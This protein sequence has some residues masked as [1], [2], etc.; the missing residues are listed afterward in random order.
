MWTDTIAALAARHR[1]YA[2][3]IIGD[4][5]F[6][7]NRRAISKPSDYV[8]WLDEVLT[9][10]VPNG[11]VSLLGIS[12]GGSIA[13]QYALRHPGRLRAVVLLAPGATVLPMSARFFLRIMFLS[14]PLPGREGSLRRVCRWLFED[15]AHGDDA[16]RARLDRA[17]EELER[18]IRVF[19]L[20]R[21][22][23]PAVLTDEEWRS[24]RVPC[25]FLVGE[26]ERIYSAEAAVR[27][28]RRVAPQVKA[29]IMR[30]AGHD[31]TLVRPDLVTAKALAF[32]SEHES[33]AAREAQTANAAPPCD[34][35]L[36][37]PAR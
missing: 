26:H 10:L 21:P 13:A 34:Y 24:F 6:S 1:T 3:D 9:A 31:L 12:L 23:W 2:L 30:G 11:A 18:V 16:C 32:L 25:L 36:P 17:M 22:P 35:A 28:L 19:A 14:V 37:D 29:E 15:A 7:V 27:R 4:A 33:V 8:E 20:P 5:G